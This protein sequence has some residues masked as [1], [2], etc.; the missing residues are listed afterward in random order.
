MQ[1]VK[2]KVGM[3]LEF[4]EKFLKRVEW[5]MKMLLLEWVEGLR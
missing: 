1:K 5:L 4:T 3:S 2:L